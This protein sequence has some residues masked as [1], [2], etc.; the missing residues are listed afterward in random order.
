M[1]AS[2]VRV[3]VIALV[4]VA[5]VASNVASNVATDNAVFV[6]SNIASNVA[7][8]ADAS[9]DASLD[10]TANPIRK[11]ITL[12]QDMQKE[13]ATEGAKEKVLYD[14]FM[15]FCNDNSGSMQ[16]KLEAGQ[17]KITELTANIKQ[18]KAEKAQLEQDLVQHNADA[19]GAKQDLDK[20]TNLHKKELK[21]MSSSLADAKTNLASITN[22]IPTLEKGMGS[23]SFAQMPESHRLRQL[24][25]SSQSMS[26]SD[27]SQLVSFLDQTGDYVPASGQIVGILKVMKS[28]MAASVKETQ[29]DMQQGKASYVDLKAAKEQEVQVAEQMTESKKKRSGEIGV[30]IVQNED[31]LADTTQEVADNQKLIA[32][33][34]AECQTKDKEWQER[35]KIRN[36]EIAA[37][38]EAISILND[39]DAMDTF[40]KAVPSAL[41]QQAPKYGF[42]GVKPH[43]RDQSHK[44]IAMLQSMA[45]AYKSARLDLIAS[46]MRTQ[47]RVSQKSGS[48]TSFA[49]ITEML[50]GMIKLQEEQQANDDN[51]VSFCKEELAKSDTEKKDKQ[52]E[53]DKIAAAMSEMKNEIDSIAD[54]LKTLTE[55]VQGLDKAVAQSTEQRKEEHAQYYQNAQ[56]TQTAIKLVGKAKNRLLK[57]YNPALH[58]PEASAP[59]PEESVYGAAASFLELAWAQRQTR[60]EQQFASMKTWGAYAKQTQ[61]S[62][63]VMQL[64]DM[65]VKELGV[66]AK[67]AEHEEKTAQKDYVELMEESKVSRA[68]DTASI[69]TKEGAKAQLEGKYTDAKQQSALT[70]D[71]LQNIHSMNADVHASCDF[72]LQSYDMRKEARTSQIEQLKEA[73]A[74]LAG[75]PA[76]PAAAAGAAAPAL[77]AATAEPAAAAAVAPEESLAF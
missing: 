61:S 19:E 68:Q 70:Q 58:K 4:A 23:A 5:V 54:D 9:A 57:F 64:M 74:M 41:V 1:P 30:S 20:A 18:E 7:A 39:D 45:Q 50:G 16:A 32:T 28:E 65:I 27:R 25:E 56:L 69:A 6:A 26:S 76:S 14:K 40:N 42:L 24:V 38:G 44:V 11:I 60:A 37:I 2:Y 12:M 52:Q 21:E 51:K 13:I 71:Q 31:G 8:N 53:A 66:S 63:G 43:K 35:S 49:A 75:A 67:E 10:A 34:T 15:C 33:L 77:P 17:D 73:Q 59:A 3:M 22:V 55:S 47:A 72:L 62:G 46:A 29:T 48:R 36:E